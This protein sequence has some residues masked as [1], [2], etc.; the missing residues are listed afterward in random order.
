MIRRDIWLRTFTLVAV[1][2]G[3]IIAAG[4][5]S[6]YLKF[7]DYYPEVL[8]HNKGLYKLLLTAAVCQFTFYIFDLYDLTTIRSLREVCRRITQAVA[9]AS[10]I[11]GI[12]FFINSA[13]QISTIDPNEPARAVSGVPTTTM[14]ITLALMICWRVA[15]HWVLNHPWFGE[16]V[17]IV[18]TGNPAIELARAVIDNKS[19]GYRVVGFV[20]EDES[21]VGQSL[22]NPTVI[23]VVGDLKEIV[24]SERV[25]RVVVALSDRRGHLP[26][27]QLLKLRLQGRVKIEEG[28]SLYERVMGK[29][30]VDMLRPSWIIFSGGSKRS[31]LWFFVR[32]VLNMVA[33]VVGLVITF[34]LWV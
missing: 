21:L 33:A 8:F 23:G 20:T 18:G 19:L 11:L 12:I 22:V 28:T 15:S 13:L 5:L 4:L 32:R 31:R 14:V 9:T 17:L 27:E 34:P 25:D 16:R 2:S 1:E 30:G 29:I 6:L 26:V 7:A 3:I 10:I 24:D